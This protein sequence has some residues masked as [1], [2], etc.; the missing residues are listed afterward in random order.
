MFY[1]SF[2]VT[3]LAILG[4]CPVDDQVLS[5]RMLIKNKIEIG[6]SNICILDYLI[7]TVLEPSMIKK[8]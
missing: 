4:M 3:I 5:G 6:S 2:I 7:L 1:Y 8:N